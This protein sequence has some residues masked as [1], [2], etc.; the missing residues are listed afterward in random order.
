MGCST[1]T[2]AVP[3]VNVEKTSSLNSV[4]SRGMDPFD[5]ILQKSSHFGRDVSY[6]STVSGNTIIDEQDLNLME[7][8]WSSWAEDDPSPAS[9]PTRRTHEVYNQAL[10]R[11][12]K[13]VDEKPK[14]FEQMVGI[15]RKRAGFEEDVMQIISV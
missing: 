15:Y 14:R 2:S 9:P 11:F 10:D 5:K 4:N 13:K 3:H 8:S 12:L 7:C 1:S 6:Q